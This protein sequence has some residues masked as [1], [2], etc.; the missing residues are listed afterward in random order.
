[1]KHSIS[2]IMCQALS[3]D[4]WKTR[5]AI[6]G[7][8]TVKGIVGLFFLEFFLIPLRQFPGV[9]LF[10]PNALAASGFSRV[11]RIPSPPP[12][13]SSFKLCLWA[14]LSY[15]PQHSQERKVILRSRS[16]SYQDSLASLDPSNIASLVDQI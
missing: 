10:L 13:K 4:N 2:S 6:V 7:L 1:M 15:C 9:S 16:P 3:L 8:L 14:E 12:A 11:L 5:E